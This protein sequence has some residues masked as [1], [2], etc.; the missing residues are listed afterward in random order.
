MLS[1]MMI[2]E[3]AC[4]SKAQRPKPTP[5][6]Q[7]M[8]PAQLVRCGVQRPRGPR[9]PPACYGRGRERWRRRMIGSALSCGAG[10]CAAGSRGVE[11][12]LW[13][14]RGLVVGG[15]SATAAPCTGSASPSCGRLSCWR[16]GCRS[17]PGRARVGWRIRPSD[18]RRGCR[19]TGH[20]H[21]LCQAQQ[22]QYENKRQDNV[23][24]SEL[25]ESKIRHA[26]RL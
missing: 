3:S 14:S 4:R 6:V 24:Q 10:F 21:K 18:G 15:A 2:G 9:H 7:G 16:L 1:E 23:C 11:E 12:A 19:S 13:T 17:K 26:C 8:P 5:L 22:T 25:S 20:R